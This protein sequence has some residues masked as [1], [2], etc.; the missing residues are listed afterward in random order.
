[1]YRVAIRSVTND[2]DSVYTINSKVSNIEIGDSNLYYISVAS[3]NFAG[4]ESLFGDEKVEIVLSEEEIKSNKIQLFQNK[5]NPFDEITYIPILVNDHQ[6][7]KGEL[8]ITNLNGELV[9]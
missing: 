2:W 5:P 3:V 7:K 6:V 8:K 4:I 1:F 9:H